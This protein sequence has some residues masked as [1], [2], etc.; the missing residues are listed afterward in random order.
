[1]SKLISL[2]MAVA[3]IIHKISDLTEGISLRDEAAQLNVNLDSLRKRFGEV[4][5]MYYDGEI[6]YYP[7]QHMWKAHKHHFL[8]TTLLSPEEAVILA[9]IRRNATHYGYGLKET[10]HRIVNRYVRRRHLRLLQK[11]SVE[12]T[13][14]NMLDTFATIKTAVRKGRYLKIIY[15]N[16]ERKVIPLQIVNL[17]FYWYLVAEVHTEKWQGILTYTAALIE[18]IQITE[19][20]F[21]KTHRNSLMLKI[22]G[23]EQG[24]NAF[25]KPYGEIKN[26]IELLVP[27]NFNTFLERAPYFSLWE[28][29][30]MRVKINDEIWRIYAVISTDENY[31]DVIPTIQKYMPKIVVRDIP[32]NADLIAKMRKS[33]EEYAA[34]FTASRSIMKC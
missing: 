19:E 12:K 10:V 14:D 31:L 28:D 18:D 22:R 21:D 4:V 23:I 15:R 32:G 33:S 13:D 25:Y 7:S 24:M 17:E 8:E 1:M 34:V 3:S 9:G 5:D 29:T 20:L 6:D 16:K 30:Q 27:D 2:D 11:D 26:K